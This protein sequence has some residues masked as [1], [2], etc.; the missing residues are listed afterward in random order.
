MPQVIASLLESSIMLIAGRTILTSFFWIAGLFGVFNFQVI[1][2]EM[3]DV[4]LPAPTLFAVATIAC[5][6]VGSAL[7]ITNWNQWGWLGAG[8]LGVFTL[9]T[10]PFGHAF[11]AFDEPRRTAEL[12]IALEHI[13][14]MGGLLLAAIS[15]VK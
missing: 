11:W 13:T 4:S 14:V 15:T 5:Q 3:R 6:L 8:A 10:I 2:Q 7:L 9:L 12:H 1:A